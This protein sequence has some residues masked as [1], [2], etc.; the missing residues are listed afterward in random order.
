MN[1]NDSSFQNGKL[2]ALPY[3]AMYIL[4]FVFSWLADFLVNRNMVQ[5]VT[6]RKIFNTI[7]KFYVICFRFI[8]YKSA[9]NL[10]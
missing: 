1:L 3:V 7:G 5:L 10:W 6:S 9:R 4:S 2:S 8:F